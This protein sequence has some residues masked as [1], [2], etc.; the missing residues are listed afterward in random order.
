LAA[1]DRDVVMIDGDAGEALI[2][3]AAMCLVTIVISVLRH[4]TLERRDRRLAAREQR[5]RADGDDAR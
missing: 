5:P 3:F 1:D 4:R 2:L